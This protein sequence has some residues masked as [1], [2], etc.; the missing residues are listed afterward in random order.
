MQVGLKPGRLIFSDW[1]EGPWQDGDSKVD[2]FQQD[3]FE[4][5]LSAKR[6]LANRRSPGSLTG[7][8]GEAQIHEEKEL[9]SLLNV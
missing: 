7:Q 4:K 2:Q 3:A 6:S 1:R 9:K 5:I 8:V